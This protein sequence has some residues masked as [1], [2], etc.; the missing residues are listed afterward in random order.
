MIS[1]PFSS[2]VLCVICVIIAR[3]GFD[4]G[5]E[6]HY[7]SISHRWLTIITFGGYTLILAAFLL[8]YVL[9]D[10]IADRMVRIGMAQLIVHF[11]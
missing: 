1:L 7:H 8:T 11:L 5:L 9:G 3:A 4:D 6:T 10:G 2:Q